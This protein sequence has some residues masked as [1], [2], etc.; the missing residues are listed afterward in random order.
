MKTVTLTKDE[1]D[2]I[3]MGLNVY[4]ICRSGC[5]YD[6]RWTHFKKYGGDEYVG[7]CFALDKDGR[8]KCRLLKSIDS[9]VE[10][11]EG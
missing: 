6:Y 7:N 2:A 10:K 8:Y 3:L 5:R 9:V 4:D 11:L 1:I